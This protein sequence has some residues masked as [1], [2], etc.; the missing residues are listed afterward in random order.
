MRKNII[1]I[2]NFIDDGKIHIIDPVW[3]PTLDSEGCL[4]LKPKNK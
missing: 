1:H 4:I 2:N 3:K